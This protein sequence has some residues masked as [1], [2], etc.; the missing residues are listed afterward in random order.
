MHALIQVEDIFSIY[1]DL[2]NNKNATLGMCIVNVLYQ[3]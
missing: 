1:C 3:L 2:T